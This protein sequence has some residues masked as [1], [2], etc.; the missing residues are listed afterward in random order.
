MKFLLF[1]K[2]IKSDS[3]EINPEIKNMHSREPYA[4]N[5]AKRKRRRDKFFRKRRRDEFFSLDTK[6]LDNILS[7]IIKSDGGIKKVILVDRTGLT[8]ASVSKFSYFPA[9]I[10]GIGAIASA[11]FSAL[12]YQGKSLRHGDLEIFTSEFSGGKIFATSCGPKGVL[13]LISDP[14]INIGLIRLILKR[15]GDELKEILGESYNMDDDDPINFI[16]FIE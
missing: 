16:R 12:E 2:L 5:G 3:R 1:N 4:A 15:S 8:L 10:D 13:T 7:K 9:D 6:S 14:E 11:I